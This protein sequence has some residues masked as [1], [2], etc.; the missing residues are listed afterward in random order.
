MKNGT[1]SS[2]AAVKGPRVTTAGICAQIGK[3]F[4]DTMQNERGI[5]FI[6]AE[7]TVRTAG[8]LKVEPTA[9]MG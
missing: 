4:P 1:W 6:R 8:W 7:D 5:E 9:F 3:E 2:R